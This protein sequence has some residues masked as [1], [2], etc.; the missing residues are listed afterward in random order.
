MAFTR[1]NVPALYA[2][3][4]ANTHLSSIV[5]KSKRGSRLTHLMKKGNPNE[6]RGEIDHQNGA[7]QKRILGC[8]VIVEVNGH[9]TGPSVSERMAMLLMKREGKCLLV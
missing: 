4:E 2:P 7:S 9:E 1:R 8:D 3:W 6:N 5:G